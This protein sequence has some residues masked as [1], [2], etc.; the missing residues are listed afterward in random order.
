MAG[1]AAS[2]IERVFRQ[3][4]GRAV[5]VLVRLLGHIDLA[6]E[7]VQEAFAEAVRRWVELILRRYLAPLPPYGPE[8]LGWPLGRRANPATALFR[9]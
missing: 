5:A 4:Y 6:E 7:A 1:A 3:E 9:R 2:E 8:G